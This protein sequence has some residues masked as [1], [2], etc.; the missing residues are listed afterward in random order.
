[1]TSAFDNPYFGIPSIRQANAGQ[2]LIRNQADARL[3]GTSIENAAS[4]PFVSERQTRH[5][6]M[7]GHHAHDHAALISLANDSDGIGSLVQRSGRT[8][9]DLR[10]AFTVLPQPQGL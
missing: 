3:L 5:E 4:T 9:L 7:T 10:G 1:M 6:P 2:R 8:Y